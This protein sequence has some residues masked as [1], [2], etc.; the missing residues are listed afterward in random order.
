MNKDSLI[1]IE[2]ILDC[3]KK[4]E[5]FSE[6]L[7]KE[8]LHTDDLYQSAIIRQIEIIG[9]AAKNIP[10]SLRNKYPKIPWKDIVGMRDKLIHHYF[11]V[12]LNTVWKVIKED[13]PD[14]K[15]KILKIKKDLKTN[16]ENAVR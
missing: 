15:E 4:I 7:T 12:N 3:I 6:G 9:E 13:L 11:G 10:D 2:H 1:F 8:K 16:Q 14:L 5:Y